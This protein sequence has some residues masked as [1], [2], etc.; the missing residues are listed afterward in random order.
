V[1]ISAKAFVTETI[2]RIKVSS[3]VF[4]PDNGDEFRIE[5]DKVLAHYSAYHIFTDPSNS[6]QN[7]KMEWSS[8]MAGH[9]TTQTEFDMAISEYNSRT[10]VAV[11]IVD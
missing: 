9:A 11:P 1:S 4:W 6:Q 3:L 10:Q 7:G 5:F 8:P 2:Q